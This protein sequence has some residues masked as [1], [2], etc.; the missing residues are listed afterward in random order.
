M[1]VA[2]TGKGG[3]GKTTIAVMLARFLADQGSEVTLIDADPDANAAMT[4][5]LAPE[6]E[7]EPLSELKDLIQDRTGASGSGGEFFSLNPKVDDIPDRFSRAAHGVRLLRMGRLAQGGSGCFCPENAFLKNLLAYIFFRED[8][9]VVL[10]MEAGVEHLG[11]GTAEGVD[12]MLAVVEP[13]RRSIQTAF[14]IRRY[15]R[16]IGIQDVGAVINKYRSEE[17]LRAVEQQI[18]DM[19]VLGRFPFDEAV[20]AADL[21]GE[22]PYRGT[23]RQKRLLRELLDAAAGART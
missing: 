11:R 12:R 23:E 21:K 4:L 13:G 5:G 2:I 15:A 8:R 6:A 9:H 7:P 16:D 3:S 10:D 14:T 22:C 20:A 17:Q 18:D 1:R 19:P